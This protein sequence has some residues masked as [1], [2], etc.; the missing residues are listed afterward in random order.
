MNLK[1]LKIFVCPKL[2]YKIKR[3]YQSWISILK[4]ISSYKVCIGDDKNRPIL[5]PNSQKYIHIITAII[6]EITKKQFQTSINKSISVCKACRGVNINKP[7]SN[8]NSQ[9]YCYTIHC[10]FKHSENIILKVLNLKY[11]H[12]LFVLNLYTWSKEQ[13]NLKSQLAKA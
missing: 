7:I 1:S 6:S 2:V 11:Q 4:S 10:S 3:T 8:L 9:K 5:N 12:S 13:N